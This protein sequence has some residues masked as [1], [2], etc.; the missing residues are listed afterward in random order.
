MAGKN[1]DFSQEDLAQILRRPETRA[2]LERL[3][4]L[5]SVALQQAVHQAMS[6]NTEGAKQ[7]L[8]PLMQDPRVQSLTDQM[9]Q[10]HGGI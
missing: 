1:Q 4:Q 6:G 8:T 2:L 3:Q 10:S 5:D 9:R 7:A